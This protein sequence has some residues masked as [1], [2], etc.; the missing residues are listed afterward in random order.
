MVLEEYKD[1]VATAAGITTVAQCFSP[2]FMC[3][4]IVQSGTSKGTDPMP[5]IGG[6]ALAVLFLKYGLIL[7]DPAMIPVNIFAFAL[8]FGYTICY[9]VYSTET[10]QLFS[11]LGKA[12]A[13]V[14]VLLG[15]T[16]WE[17]QEHVEFRFGLIVTVLML[18]LIGSPLLSLKEIIRTKS[19]ESLPFPLIA[20]GTVVTL[21]W[22][23]YGIIIDNV[24]MKVQNV[25]A[26]ILSVVQL[27]LFV[28]YPS[29]PP[30]KQEKK[31]N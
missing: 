6:M 23:L 11:A 8:N 30:K 29:S 26:L 19:T 16:Q 10:S 13:L 24:F 12:T 22:L 3:K 20:S 31:K 7:N 27:S 21:L 25:I 4:K 15:Y 17:A 14:A 28:I 9:Y 5:F 1:L 18:G 2:I